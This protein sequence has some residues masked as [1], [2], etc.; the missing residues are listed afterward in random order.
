VVPAFIDAHTYLGIK[1][2]DDR[3]E[4][5][6]AIYAEF[7][8]ADALEGSTI[9]GA[10][11]FEE[12]LLRAYV[13]PG[14]GA[15]VAGLGA[16][17]DL[18]RG[19]VA[20]GVLT[21]STTDDTLSRDREPTAPSGVG[22]VMREQVPPIVKG[23]AV[24]RVFAEQPHEIA[25]ALGCA[26]EAGAR[27]VLVGVDRPDL[28]ADSEPPAGTAVIT[29]PSIDP[30]RLKRLAHATGKGVRCAFASWAAD[31]WH[32]NI[33]FLAS[34]AHAYGVSR[35]A[36]LAGLTVDAAYACDLGGA[37]ALAVGGRADLNIFGG[38]PLD[39]RSPLLY[40]VAGG[41]IRHTSEGTAEAGGTAP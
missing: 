13:S 29:R 1:D 26:R 38:D 37:G 36:A 19:D 17:I 3:N 5:L 33:R 25:L 34:V 4:R 2:R 35:E 27:A 41:R 28:L 11:L 8:I 22:L 18:A 39:L 9:R 7:K 10:T 16:V 31:E 21:L 15:V 20:P 6:R 40:V 30:V 12:G 14:P 24:V 23:R 32:V